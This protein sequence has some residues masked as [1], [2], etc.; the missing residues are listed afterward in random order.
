MWALMRVFALST[1]LE[2]Q[3]MSRAKQNRK[4]SHRIMASGV[5][6]CPGAWKQAVQQH[7]SLT[8]S[9][10]NWNKVPNATTQDERLKAGQGEKLAWKRM[11]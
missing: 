1:G 3:E 5:R 7:L 6:S 11:G 8:A 4:P 10:E 2:G 9:T